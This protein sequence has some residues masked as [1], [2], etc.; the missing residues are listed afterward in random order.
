MRYSLSE[1]MKT[2]RVV[3]DSELSIRQTLKELGILYRSNF[4]NWYRRYLGDG[5]E[6]LN[7]RKPEPSG[8][9]FRRKSKSRLF[10]RLW[11]KWNSHPENW[12]AGSLIRKSTS[13][14]N[15]EFIGFLRAMI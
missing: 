10:V 6:V 3:E 2:I 8:T 15:P 7:I 11:N 13:F 5:V 1:K 14:Q 9:R 4:Y 12:L